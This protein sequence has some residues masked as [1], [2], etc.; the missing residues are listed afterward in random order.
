[1]H[2]K[3]IH[4][5]LE[6]HHFSVLSVWK[7]FS[8][9]YKSVFCKKF[10]KFKYVF[11]QEPSLSKA[12]KTTF[13]V[14]T[15]T[16]EATFRQTRSEINASAR[17]GQSLIMKKW[18]WWG[19]LTLTWAIW[20]ALKREKSTTSIQ[21]HSSVTVFGNDGAK[22]DSHASCLKKHSNV[23]EQWTSVNKITLSANDDKRIIQPGKIQ[24]LAYGFRAWGASGGQE[25][26]GH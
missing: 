9:A 12:S 14:L 3:N 17:S 13:A 2:L 26:R 1:M 25:Q 21:S 19:N 4:Y 23:K 24:T 6:A 20:K 5:S 7:F 8:Q 10:S 22:P 15:P 16:L 11:L 18:Q